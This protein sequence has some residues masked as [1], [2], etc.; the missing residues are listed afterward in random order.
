[1]Y[2]IYTCPLQL[3]RTWRGVI[4]MERDITLPIL[5]GDCD[6][7]ESKRVRVPDP[8][9]TLDDDVDEGRPVKLQ[10]IEDNGNFTTKITALHIVYEFL[11]VN[12]KII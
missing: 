8:G 6:S 12:M 4:V 3:K 7:G 10:K 2:I 11:R 9:F 5:A 1:M